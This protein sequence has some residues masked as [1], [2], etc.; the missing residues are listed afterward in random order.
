MPA[1]KQTP[2]LPKLIEALIKQ[3]EVEGKSVVLTDLTDPFLLGAWFILGQH[4]KRNG[5]NRAYEAL[6]RAKGITPGQL[7]DLPPEKLLTICQ[8]AGP[9]E[10]ARSKD[11][12]A[13]ADDIED[14]C[15]QD[16]SQVFKKSAAEIRK[17]LE[18][19][20]KRSRAFTDFLLLYGGRQPIFPVDLPVARAATRL[21]YGKMRSEK[22][23]EKAYKDIQKALESES[24]KEPDWLIRAHSALHRHGQE[25]CITHPLCDKCSVAK[26]CPYLK[27]NPLPPKLPTAPTSSTPF[28]KPLQ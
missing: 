24:S 5:Q 19:D 28:A 25:T 21:G 11:L 9:Y 3:Y 6:R 22:E 18:V 7:L 16:F 8:T 10:D 1:A 17:F 4:A 14:K 26:D 27:K 20:L 13:F 15:G 2:R 23:F 12:Y